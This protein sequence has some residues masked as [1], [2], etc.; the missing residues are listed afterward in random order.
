MAISLSSLNLFTKKS[1]NGSNQTSQAASSPLFAQKEASS[2]EK[3]AQTSMT[4][5]SSSDFLKYVYNNT[6][7]EETSGN[8]D[9]TSK[10]VMSS[11]KKDGVTLPR[12]VEY[13]SQKVTTT[14]KTLDQVVSAIHQ[15]LPTSS[16]SAIKSE[17]QKKYPSTG[18]SLNMNA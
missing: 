7:S 3:T 17:L 1:V 13:N 2:S 14:G 9:S 6:A 15:K 5:M 11:R 10:E 16:K 8:N 12:V 18:G 4:N